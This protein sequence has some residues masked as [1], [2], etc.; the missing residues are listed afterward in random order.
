MDVR[1]SFLLLLGLL[2]R[3]RLTRYPLDFVRK[4]EGRPVI[5]D[6]LILIDAY[7]YLRFPPETM[8]PDSLLEGRNL[9]NGISVFFTPAFYIFS[10]CSFLCTR[11]SLG[12]AGQCSVSCGGG[13]QT[14]SIQCLRQGRPAAGCL[15]HQRPV[16]SRACNTQ[17]CPSA[18]SVPAQNSGR[19]T[20][21]RGKEKRAN[22]SC[23]LVAAILYQVI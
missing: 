18:P 22:T 17:F 8:A 4:S 19:A 21:P 16:T 15:P 1:C 3:L 23:L 20:V 11:P 6:H 10:F 7:V 9:P 14:R 2:E 12:S 5:A 13:V